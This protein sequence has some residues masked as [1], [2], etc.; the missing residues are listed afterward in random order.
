MSGSDAP[1]EQSVPPDRPSDTRRRVRRPG[2]LAGLVAAAALVPALVGIPA[3]A[4]AAGPYTLNVSPNP[5]AVDGEL[6]IEG[7]G[8][9]PFEEVHFKMWRQLGPSGFEWFDTYAGPAGDFRYTASLGGIF[10]AGQPIG[11]ALYCGPVLDPYGPFDASTTF[12]TA[13]APATIGMSL[14]AAATSYGAGAT[15]SVE[16]TPY[17]NGEHAVKLVV[18][19]TTTLTARARATLPEPFV[20]TLPRTLGVGT[21]ELVATYTPSGGTGLDPVSTSAT[22]SVTRATSSTTLFLSFASWRYGGTRGLA[23]VR[24]TTTA[25]GSVK[26]TVGGKS[27]L[28]AVSAGKAKLRLPGLKVGSAR[29]RATF[30]PTVAGSADRSS[31]VKT[32]TVK[33]AKP[34]VT[35]GVTKQPVNL[36][37]ST[38]AKVR[39]AVP[40][41]AKPTG[42]VVIRDGKTTIARAKL[43]SA[44]RGLLS[45]RLPAFWRSGTHTL[46]AKYLGNSKILAKS[47]AA[48]PVRVRG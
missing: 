16:V 17:I 43:A 37:W 20:F 4:Q 40:G 3:A 9:N 2:R 10:D 6:T 30:V 36:G 23:A 44:A 11:V 29:V 13:T 7:S 5:V 45:V 33:K 47:S 31:V 21:H 27:Y 18:D 15:A 34:K 24:V 22:Y 35:L 38:T 12:N 8:C 41:I 32:V 46:T 25:P 42:T 14:S 48:K 39:V 1:F 28:R 26:F 19:G